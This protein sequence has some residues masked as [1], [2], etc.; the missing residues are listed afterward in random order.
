ML[1]NNQTPASAQRVAV[2]LTGPNDWEE[3]I[4]VVKTKALAG[5]IWEFVN[6]STEKTRLP[7][8]ERPTIPMA[9]NVNPAKTAISILSEDEKEELKL[10]CYSYKH[11]LTDLSHL[12]V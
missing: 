7:V 9:N 10:L 12:H 1:N 8:L 5:K 2:I 11:N 4:E 3:W 6:L